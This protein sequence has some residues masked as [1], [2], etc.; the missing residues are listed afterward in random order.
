MYEVSPTCVPATLICDMQ[1]LCVD[2]GVFGC[3]HATGVTSK[4]RLEAEA[5]GPDPRGLATCGS[6]RS[7]DTGKN[8]L[9]SGR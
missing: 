6:E 4:L 1:L 2:T 3:T 8:P 7:V 9:T 5:S